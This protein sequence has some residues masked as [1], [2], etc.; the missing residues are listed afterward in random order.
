MM[1]VY[2]RSPIPIYGTVVILMVAYMTRFMTYG[3]RY[4]SSAMMQIGDELEEAA[5][6]NGATWGTAFRRIL[7]PMAAPGILSGWIFV[8]LVSFREL[9]STILLAGPDSEVLSVILFR[10]YGEGTF[11]VVAALSLLMIGI[12]SLIVGLAYWIGSRFGTR[13]EL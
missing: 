1:A 4:A 2:L 7:L 11:G 5:L 13:I 12:L 9:A 6:V 10:Q 3:M 8:F